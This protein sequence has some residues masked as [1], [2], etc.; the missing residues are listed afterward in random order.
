MVHDSCLYIC[1]TTS[2]SMLL[3]YAAVYGLA[4]CLIITY[5]AH[6]TRHDNSRCI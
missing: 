1:R 3:M 6:D 2:V 5:T 4:M